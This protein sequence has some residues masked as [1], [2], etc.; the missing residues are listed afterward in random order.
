MSEEMLRY[1]RMVEAA[2]RGVVRQALR[3]VL[4][5]GGQLPGEHH[6]YITFRTDA[7]GVDIPDYL[8]AKYP[9]EMTIVLQYQFYDLTVE[10]D[11]FSVTLSF[12][13][14][15][16]RLVIPF[17][18]IIT[19]ADPSVNFVLQ[20]QP[21]DLP[22]LLV[23]EEESEGE[24]ENAPVASDEPGDD[25]PKPTGTVVALDAFRKK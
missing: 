15:L 8:R 12:G 6:F 2:K 9:T 23:D 19:F 3:E 13:G 18:H 7:E 22:D 10:N 5:R 4:S 11:K 21:D 25:Q 20:F 1:D 24:P 16:R 14:V 17:I